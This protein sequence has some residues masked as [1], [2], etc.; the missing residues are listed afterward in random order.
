M[1]TPATRVIAHRGNLNGPST[2][3][4]SLTLVR[5]AVAQNW[6]LELDLRRDDRGHYYFSHELGVRTDANC[7]HSIL[8]VIRDAV[9]PFLALNVKELGYESAIVDLLADYALTEASF[10]FDMEL[11]ETDPG[12]TARRLRHE[13]PDAH[14][15]VR[16]SD[17]DEPMERAL[18]ENA[19]D[20]VWL[21]EFEVLW[22]TKSD[23]QRLRDSGRRVYAVSPELHGFSEGVRRQRWLEFAQWG[24]DGI[25]TDYP[26][27]L[28]HLLN[29]EGRE[30]DA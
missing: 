6:G 15:A 13:R 17:H 21:D 9:E 14:I 11:I 7:A 29:Q 3:E 20:V 8:N 16:V 23:V 27:E 2:G 30:R 28:H 12:H 4:N 10:V 19:A 22:A 18:E 1:R 25:C 24:V 26:E 5:Q